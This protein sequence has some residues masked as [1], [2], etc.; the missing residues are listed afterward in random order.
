MFSG[1]SPHNRNEIPFLDFAE[2]GGGED[3]CRVT[4][5]PSSA[6][7]PHRGLMDEWKKSSEQLRNLTEWKTPE[8]VK[9]ERK[10]KSDTGRI[11]LAIIGSGIFA[12]ILAGVTNREEVFWLAWIVTGIITASMVMD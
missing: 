7:T 11:W 2:L 10:R 9:A 8:Q 5:S 1:Q 3:Y 6:Y 12:A 4:P